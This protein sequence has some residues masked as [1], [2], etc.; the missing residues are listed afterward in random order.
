M[1]LN[2]NSE[3]L[4]HLEKLVKEKG[5]TIPNSM[6]KGFEVPKKLFQVCGNTITHIT[7]SVVIDEHGYHYDFEAIPFLDLINIVDSIK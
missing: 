3:V 5:Y 1:Y 6:S 2:L 4:I 7:S